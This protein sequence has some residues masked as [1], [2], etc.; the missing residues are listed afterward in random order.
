MT[1]KNLRNIHTTRNSCM[2][3]LSCTNKALIVVPQYFTCWWRSLLPTTSK[4]GLLTIRQ[5]STNRKCLFLKVTDQV[6]ERQKRI[7]INTNHSYYHCSSPYTSLNWSKNK[8]RFSFNQPNRKR[9][10]AKLVDVKYLPHMAFLLWHQH[11]KGRQPRLK[12]Y[13]LPM[14]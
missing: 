8:A 1:P 10:G 4:F 12:R 9:W 7:S 2:N 5:Y 14:R 3:T 6:W 13:L 11:S